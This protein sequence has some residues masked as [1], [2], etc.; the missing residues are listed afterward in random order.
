EHARLYGSRYTDVKEGDHDGKAG[1]FGTGGMQLSRGA[2]S[3]TPHYAVLRSV[4]GAERA[5]YHAVF[6]SREA[7]A[8]G[9]DDNQCPRCRDGDGPNDA[10][11]EHPAS[12]TRRP[13]RC[14]AGQPRSPEQG[15][16]GHR[17]RRSPFPGRDEGMGA[18]AAAIREGVRSEAHHRHARPPARRCRN[19]PRP[20]RRLASRTIRSFRGTAAD[21]GRLNLVGLDAKILREARPRRVGRLRMLA[22]RFWLPSDSPRSVA[23]QRAGMAGNHQVFVCLDDISGDAAAWRA[24]AQL[25]VAVRRL[26]QVEPQPLACPADRA[27]HRRRILTDPGR[28]DDGVEA[29]ECR[30]ER[31]DM[32][33]N[34]IAK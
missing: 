8:V 9:T 30:R 14:R 17:G 25:L 27:A 12:G 26:V 28:E 20:Y 33:G 1:S 34:A 18:S 10:R 6:N 15:A 19:R 31:S 21:K 13:D 3:R 23:Y 4:S 11:P 24:D 32:T 22:V 2:P 5:A 7:A 16:A 29:V